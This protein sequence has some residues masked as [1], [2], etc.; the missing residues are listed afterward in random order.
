VEQSVRRLAFSRDEAYRDKVLGMLS[1]VTRARFLPGSDFSLSQ[2]KRDAR[3]AEL[4]FDYRLSLFNTRDLLALSTPETPF[5]L[6]SDKPLE[7]IMNGK[8]DLLFRHDGRFYIL[9]WKSNHLGY[10]LADYGR[11]GVAA[12]MLENNYHLQYLIYTVAVCRYLAKRVKNFDYERDFGGVIYL[13]VRGV[14]ADQDTGVFFIKPSLA[15]VEAIE[16]LMAGT[17]PKHGNINKK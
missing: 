11:E 14:R 15:L 3:L 13:F 12:A 17:M 5:F 4:E 10:S 6:E 2:L 16:G 9:D 1:Q 8:I 7:G